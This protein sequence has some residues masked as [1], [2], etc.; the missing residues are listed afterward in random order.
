[1]TTDDI[2]RMKYNL[3]TRAAWEADENY[4]FHR[5]HIPG[6]SRL[7]CGGKCGQNSPKKHWDEINL[8][9][10]KEKQRKKIY[11]EHEKAAEIKK[12]RSETPVPMESVEKVEEP[13][14]TDFVTG[15]KV[16]SFAEGGTTPKGQK[17]NR[18]T[19]VTPEPRN[20]DG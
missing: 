17:K 16:Q 12:W 9:K 5:F 18:V 20:V 14:D 11:G 2:S 19:F 4:D 7:E 6:C 1:M 10:E 13:G 3:P 15:A 8:R